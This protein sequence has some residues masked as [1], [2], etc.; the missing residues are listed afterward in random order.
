MHSFDSVSIMVIALLKSICISLI[1]SILSVVSCSHFHLRFY[2]ILLFHFKMN[3]ILLTCR[4]EGL[5]HGRWYNYSMRSLVIGAHVIFDDTIGKI[6]LGDMFVFRIAF[7]KLNP[8]STDAW[9]WLKIRMNLWQMEA[10]FT[11]RHLIFWSRSHQAFH[12]LKQT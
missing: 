7:L 12:L 9:P 4:S 1:L 6:M 5:N 11:S 3:I 10:L 2:F 8:R